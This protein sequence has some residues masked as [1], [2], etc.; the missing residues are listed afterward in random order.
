MTRGWGTLRAAR[1]VL[2]VML[3]T[4]LAGTGLSQAAPVSPRD[5]AVST[6]T[7]TQSPQSLVVD[8]SGTYAYVV[9]YQTYMLY[10][11]RLS[12]F[13]IDDSMPLPPDPGGTPYA[14]GRAVALHGT[15]VYVTTSSRL[16]RANAVNLPASPDDSVGIPAFGQFMAISWPYAYVTHHADNDYVT[17]VNLAT[18]T[19]VS[20]IASGGSY[21]M[22]IAL[23]DTYAYVVNTVSS[24]LSRIR[25]ST[26]T[27]DDTL[28]IGQQPYGI[29][30]DGSQAFAYVPTASDQSW[31]GIVNPP[32][33]VRVRLSTFAVDDT[34][35]LP[36]TWGFGV[37]VNPLGTTAYVTQTRGGNQVA[38]IGLGAQMTLDGAT[39]AVGP[40]PQAVTVSPTLPYFYTADANDTN[41]N[42]IT[43][44]AITVATPSVASLSAASG[45]LAGGAQVTISGTRLTGATAVNFGSV[46]A[47]IV[48][49]TDD[50]VLV[51]V[52]AAGSAGPQQVTVTTPGGTSTDNVLYTYVDEP[53]PEP[54]P[55]PPSET[56][57]VS[58]VAGDR[59]AR[60]SWLPPSVSGSFPVS[61]YQVTASPGGAGCLA[62]ALSCVVSGLVNGRTYSFTVRALS[63]AGWGDWS[64]PSDNV[65]PRGVIV[66]TGSRSGQRIEVQGRALPGDNVEPWV[67]LAGEQAFTNALRSVVA[68]RQGQFAWT[69]RAS[70]AAS[71]YVVVDGI[72]SNT[73]DIPARRR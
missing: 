52:P 24:T 11:V 15:D 53:A 63:G 34:V 28:L 17:K 37:A 20:S 18:M 8:D 21:P 50:T 60:V 41:G 2:A 66:L 31:G 33:L 43:K 36:F 64:A 1:T 38:K 13:T 12:D 23:D 56:V 39:I 54:A 59:S 70:R 61:T 62:A 14:G 73:V 5:S 47:T 68:G 9:T 45:P 4:G 55:T 29:A 6:L 49:G 40:G 48:S 19:V 16:Y 22:G 3:V 30:V 26:F 25:L 67:R 57:S 58:A 27:V 72:E 42:T 10:K 71:V 35:G 51:T 65:T 7:L 69:R 46:P 32:W 44:V